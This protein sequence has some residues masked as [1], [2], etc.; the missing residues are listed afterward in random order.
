MYVLNFESEFK[1]LYYVKYD[2][3]SN[4]FHFCDDTG[5]LLKTFPNI[6]SIL[7]YVQCFE[8]NIFRITVFE[9]NANTFNLYLNKDDKEMNKQKFE[10]IQSILEPYEDHRREVNDMRRVK[11]IFK[12][13]ND[14]FENVLFSQPKKENDNEQLKDEVKNLKVED[15]VKNLKVEDEVKNLKVEDEVKKPKI[16]DHSETTMHPIKNI[17]NSFIYESD[18]SD[19]SYSSDDDDDEY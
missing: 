3:S 11:K 15:E 13:F 10:Y 16:K 17:I 2:K 8:T 5:A 19:V 4:S 6:K 7:L 14:L 1:L 18:M 12:K 9:K